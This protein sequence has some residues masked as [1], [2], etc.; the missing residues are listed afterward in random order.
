MSSAEVEG[1]R[2]MESSGDIRYSLWGF[3]GSFRIKGKQYWSGFWG[4]REKSLSCLLVDGLERD[5]Q[6]GFGPAECVLGNRR[7]K[8]RKVGVS[9]W[10]VYLE[11]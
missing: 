7:E 10:A 8:V 11:G 9:A 4:E 2:F 5:L 6:W 1:R 3:G